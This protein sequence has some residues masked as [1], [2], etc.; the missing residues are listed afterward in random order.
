MENRRII[1]D[2]NEDTKKNEQETIRAAVAAALY[3][4][5]I[6]MRLWLFI[7]FD[8]CDDDAPLQFQ[9]IKSIEIRIH[10]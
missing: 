10:L 4:H 5:I 1:D 2:K 6:T 8:I 9:L 7:N 3:F